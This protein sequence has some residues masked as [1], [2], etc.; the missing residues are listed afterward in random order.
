MRVIV[1]F[2]E[3]APP[4]LGLKLNVTD[5]PTL[6]MTL[7]MLA[8]LNTTIVTAPPMYEDSVLADNTMSLLVD[9]KTGPPAVGF[10]A[11]TRPES[12]IATGLSDTM[13]PFCN[14]ITMLEVPL[15]FEI[16]VAYPFNNITEGVNPVW[17]N[18]YG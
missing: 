10:A 13:N 12:V 18:P 9:I 8:I 2:G 6:P 5:I 16:A 1:L 11:I 4:E 17:K 3:R 15:A 7:S 14:V